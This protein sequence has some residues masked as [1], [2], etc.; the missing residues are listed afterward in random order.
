MD[1]SNIN[2]F[3]FLFNSDTGNYV[4]TYFLNYLKYIIFIFVNLILP[5]LGK[6]ND[7]KMQNIIPYI[8]YGNFIIL[9]LYIL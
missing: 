3:S 8:I 6:V 1:L 5:A 2:V 7:A 9:L 4:I